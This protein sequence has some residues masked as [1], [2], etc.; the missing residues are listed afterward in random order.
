MALFRLYLEQDP[1]RAQ[2]FVAAP[3]ACAMEDVEAPLRSAGFFDALAEF[4]V[5]K[6]RP[7]EALRLWQQ[8]S[9]NG[10]REA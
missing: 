7:R 3:N 9:F 6:S 1:A 4:F 10:P 8:F 5:Q 2:K